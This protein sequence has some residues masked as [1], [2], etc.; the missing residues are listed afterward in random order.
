M[1]SVRT[2]KWFNEKL[3]WILD[4]S[5]S[6]LFWGAAIWYVFVNKW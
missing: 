6:V 5:F 1:A 2:M 3:F 4:I